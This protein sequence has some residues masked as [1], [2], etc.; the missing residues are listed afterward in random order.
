M[1]WVL[2]APPPLHHPAVRGTS[3]PP[4]CTLYPHITGD[5]LRNRK[6]SRY[7]GGNPP[8]VQVVPR[9]LHLLLSSA[10][11]SRSCPD[12][13]RAPGPPQTRDP[14]QGVGGR[15][16]RVLDVGLRSGNT[17]FKVGVSPETTSWLG[18]CT[19]ESPRP[20]LVSEDPRPLNPTPK[21]WR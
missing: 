7:P 10:V 20:L 4:V 3:H 9:P 5:P 2:S 15:G 11:P 6:S 1:G 16:D 19:D 14:S 8:E 21:V 18:E 13:A 17:V 12:W